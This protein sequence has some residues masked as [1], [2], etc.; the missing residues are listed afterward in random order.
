MK[1][2]ANPLGE[3]VEYAI[4]VEFQA[5][6]SPHAHNVIWIKS[7][8]KFGR[9]SDESVC[10]FIDKYVSCAI[11][12]NECK[13]KQ[14]VSLLQQHKHSSYCK[15]GRT[16]RFNFPQPPS[17][18]TL[19][20][21][22]RTD[23][24]DASIDMNTVS[25]ALSRVRK[26]LI[27]GDV[28]VSIEQLLNNAK[29]PMRH[30]EKAL[31]ISTKGNAIVLKREPKECKINNYNPNVMLAWQANMD[32]QFVLNAYACVMYVASY[33]MKSERAMGELLRNV[34]K[35]NRTDEMKL[36]LRKVGSAFLTHCE[37]SAQEAV[38]RI[39]SM[40]MKQLSRTVVFVDTNP[41]TNIIGI[42]KD[43]NAISQLDDGDTNVFQ[44]S[45]IDR[46]EHRPNTLDQMCLAE[47]AANY[48]TSYKCEENDDV[49][50]NDETVELCENSK[51]KL[52]DGY[53]T[54]YKRRRE[55]VIRFTR[56][57][58]D[59]EPSNYYRA[60]LVLYYPW[61]NEDIDLLG[62]Y[63]TYEEHY[64]HVQDVVIDNESKYNE[65]PDNNTEYNENGPPEHL[66]A[67][68]AP[69]TEENRLNALREGEEMLTNLNQDDINDN[70]ALL[71][72]VSSSTNVF[73][74]YESA[75]NT[76]VLSPEEYRKMM[77]QLNKK[78]KQIVM[79]HRRWCKD[80]IVCLKRGENV[81]PYQIFLSGPGGVGKSHVIKLVQS[82]TI[83]LLKLSGMFEPDDVIVLLTVPTGVA[84][85]NINGMTIH[86]ALLLGCNRYTGF[87]PLSNDRL[88]TLRC[89][90]S[91][92][93]LIIIDEVSMVGSNMLLEIHKR[94]QQIKGVTGETMFGNVSVL[95][96]GDLYQLP[97]IGQAAIFYK[98]TDSYAQLYKS[99][100]L[101]ID[102]FEMLELDE[103]MRQRN[104]VRFTEL[105]CRMRKA[106]CTSEDIE[107]L[108]ACEI[109]ENCNNYPINA[110][111]VFR[112][113]VDVDSRNEIMLNSIASEDN[114]YSV[115]ARDSVA[116]QTRHINLNQILKKRSETVGGLHDVLKI[117]VNARVMLTANVDVS[118]GLV[119]GAM[120]TIKHVI[121]N[122]KN[123]VTV[124]LVHFD[125]TSIGVKCIQTSAYKQSY[126]NAVPICKH[127]VQ[128]LA[129]RKKGA[130]I[131]RIQFPL[132]LAWATTIHKV[133][134]LTLD[135]IVV[136]MKGGHFSP[137]QAYV[138]CSR[139][140][141]M[142]GLH[143]TNLNV[144]AIKKSV[145][146]ETEM[147][148]LASKLI[149]Y[150]PIPYIDVNVRNHGKRLLST[151]C[152]LNV[153]S[154]SA[155]ID[156][157]KCDEFYNLLMYYAYVKHG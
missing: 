157:I 107:L 86:S 95:A 76:D 9:D 146:V 27:D 136:D 16:C 14:L 58:K 39:L 33:M 56:F 8:P 77:R 96:V 3:V 156:D 140:K 69:N 53:G 143:I 150:D 85:F 78:Q 81:K 135:E 19:I 93:M 15:R 106:E 46:Y 89:K 145:K 80:A 7:A 102:E 94:L 141:N 30:Y 91:K 123:E 20:A 118:D 133:Q 12:E 155:K 127:E 57:N 152:C 109:T 121:T 149:D 125:T 48:V 90:L 82:D 128:F 52:R 36:Q 5:R 60:K 132:T 101:W 61:R 6:G 138:A 40:P 45:L 21:Y 103:I 43:L 17:T 37:V 66:W 126:P 55:A 59:K 70:N 62:N 75:C 129:R 99:G 88:T 147:Q 124:I 47:F 64:N 108:K 28:D 49:L 51:I 1:S 4:R 154:L 130:E 74:R 84:A 34:A 18:K 153:R 97:P 112:L 87:Q 139:V 92:L 2:N 63:E 100:S 120:G 29:V 10:K 38:Y 42:L 117:A 144:T 72:N 41:K 25:N 115:E 113:N 54:M 119:N 79:Y 24:D 35:E 50:P 105:L 83:K 151:L 116:G 31:E 134:G 23:E 26:E 11:P 98:V 131:N 142:K 111:H 67:G 137:G 22:P 110:L 68:I 114:Q 148:R 71:T 65:I 32:I 104:D 73:Q 44:K 122:D 13:L